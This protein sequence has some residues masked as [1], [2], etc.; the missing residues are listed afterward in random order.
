MNDWRTLAPQEIERRSMEMIESELGDVKAEGI[1]RMVLKR[2]IHT[3]A[4][5]SYA[6]NLFFSPD[7][8]EK[9]IEAL[10]S[11]ADII[12]DT[13]MAKS[14]INR[15]ALK[16]LGCET[17]C[18]M[19]DEAVAAQAAARSITR[20]AVSME[21]AA[22]I[23]KPL[24]IAVGN[25]PT[26]LLRLAEL[27]EEGKIEPKLIIAAPV[28]FVNVVE[29]KQVIEKCGVPVICARGRRGGSTVAVAICNALLYEAVNR[30]ALK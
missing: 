7:A 11:G 25:A 30:K 20:A 19:A 16:K 10:L 17:H 12:T 28:G 2:V 18:F 1:E 15:S 3:T 8:A 5:F 23:K 27:I 13:N 9:G 26:A 14:G 4:D 6:E 22:A 21:H 24:I 29:S